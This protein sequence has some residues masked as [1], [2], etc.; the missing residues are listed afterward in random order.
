MNEQWLSLSTHGF[1]NYAVSSMRRLFNVKTNRIINGSKTTEGYIRVSFINV[2][3][4]NKYK[5]LHVLI[6]LLF[7][8]KSD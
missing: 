6:A 2:N 8:T 1:T 7:C 4:Q 5:Y 3:N